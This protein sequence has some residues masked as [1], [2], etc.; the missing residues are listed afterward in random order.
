MTVRIHPS[1][2]VEDNVS[3]GEG[4][5]IWDSVHIRHSTQ[6]GEECIVGEKT[7]I[8]YGVKIGDRVKI[9]AFVYICNAVTIEDGVM[10]S[11]GTIFT[12]DRFPRATTSD[13]KKL[14]PSDPD[15]HTLPT[16][17]QAG[18]TIGAGCT[19]GNDLTIGRFAMIG[20]GSLVTKSVPDFHL[21]IGHPAKSV[22]C[23]CRC[24]QLLRR[25]PVEGNVDESEIACSA[26]G[27]KY[28]IK[29]CKVI[30]L[31]HPC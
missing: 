3:I 9:N 18:A 30:E 16:L 25:F 2:I 24:G 8:A 14:R 11:A 23:V 13:L 28:E 7:Y 29:E 27:L 1:A 4:S 22:G 15:E 6:I 17:V 21:V 26:C 31:A 20:M 10:I 5:S 12:N 19:I